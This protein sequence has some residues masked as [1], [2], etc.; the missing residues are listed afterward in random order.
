MHTFKWTLTQK[1]MRDKQTGRVL[2]NVLFDKVNDT[3]L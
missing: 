3:M 1:K 2:N